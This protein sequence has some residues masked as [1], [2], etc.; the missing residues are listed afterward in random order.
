MYAQYKKQLEFDQYVAGQRENFT[1]LSEGL[2]DPNE[3][4]KIFAEILFNKNRDNLTDDL[5]GILIDESMENADIFCMLLELVLCGVDR[6]THQTANILDLTDQTDELVYDVKAYFKSIGFNI[7]IK[8]QFIELDQIN[9]YRDRD[10]YYCQITS[11]P[12][13]FLC[14]PGWYVLNYR[15]IN[16]PKFKF[17]QTTPIEN[18]KAFFISK[19]KQVFVIGFERAFKTFQN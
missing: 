4:V 8:E 19:S 3:S 5:S 7:K 18:F 14:H 12:P 11:R 17:D 15:L 1:D 9:L 2:A 13:P 6:L 16:N 10:D